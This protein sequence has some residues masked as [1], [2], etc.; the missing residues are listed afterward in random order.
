MDIDRATIVV[1]ITL[2]VIIVVNA[3]I[4]VS[5]RRGNQSTAIDMLRKVMTRARD[6]WE[7]ED[8]ALQELSEL[9][10]QFRADK[11][12]GNEK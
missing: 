8:Q 4:Y 10:S 3:A 9:T 11:D 2:F 5:F 6:P 1:C 12:K 7:A